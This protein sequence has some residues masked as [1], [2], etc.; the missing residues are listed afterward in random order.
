MK[1]GNSLTFWE[2]VR[3]QSTWGKYLTSI[4]EGA[5][6]TAMNA[7]K[8]PSVALEIGTEGGYWTQLLVDRGWKVICT[9]VDEKALEL[10]RQRVPSATCIRVSPDSTTLPC[11]SGSVNL[12]VCFE[13]FPVMHSD[14]FFAEAARVL[15]PGGVL[16]GVTH[17]RNSIRSYANKL[18][19][20]VEK[21]RK[22]NPDNSY[23]Y[24]LAYQEWK[25][26]VTETGFALLHEEGMC[27]LPFP[28]KSNF[29]LIPQLT[30]LE[31]VLGL[32]QL[33]QFSPW[34][35]FVAQ[36]RNADLK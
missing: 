24:R 7:T 2:N 22:S 17:N 33:T 13:V 27:W 21:E 25:Q 32:R 15:A 26:H 19:S 6:Q 9:E 36:K 11:N 14:W 5:L 10:C 12:I 8:R 31:Q 30:R 16:A 28:R 1:S 4:E 18:I 34:I 35:A 23:L 29:F 3:Q 20:S